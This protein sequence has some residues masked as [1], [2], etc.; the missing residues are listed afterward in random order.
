[1]DFSSHIALH[2]SQSITLRITL[3]ASHDTQS[4]TEHIM[5]LRTGL[6]SDETKMMRQNRL[7]V[8]GGRGRTRTDA[9]ADGRGRTRTDADI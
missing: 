7:Y 6:N 4:A 2:I 5:T 3:N 8:F 9:D 1:M